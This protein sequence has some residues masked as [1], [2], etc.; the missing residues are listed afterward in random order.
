M[1]APFSFESMLVFGWLASML[2][3]G[4]LLRAKISFFQRFL[5]PGC[6]IGGI[7]GLIL[8][9]FGAIK[10]AVSDLELF[11]YHFFNISFIDRFGK[12]RDGE[13]FHL[14]FLGFTFTFPDF[15]C[16]NVFFIKF[17]F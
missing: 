15:T 12:W 14:Q 7:I 3:M 11:A 8:I 5:F 2:L 17:L 4:V 9:N 1:T 13:A 10:I 16:I 6:L